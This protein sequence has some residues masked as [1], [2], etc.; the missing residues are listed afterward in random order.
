MLPTL[1]VGICKAFCL[2]ESLHGWGKEKFENQYASPVCL[3]TKA[4]RQS[5]LAPVALVRGPGFLFP[6]SRKCAFCLPPPEA[7]G[8]LAAGSGSCS[9][10]VA[11]EASGCPM[12][13]ILALCPSP[14]LCVSS[15]DL[16]TLTEFSSISVKDRVEMTAGIVLLPWPN[17][18]RR[19]LTEYM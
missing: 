3:F 15:S 14:W 2:K 16:G 5:G 7:F 10:R 1:Q 13:T 9:L 11:A 18:Q 19:C 6:R 17:L 4:E 8:H 12:H